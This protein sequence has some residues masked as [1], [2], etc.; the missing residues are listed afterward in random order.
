MNQTMKKIFTAALVALVCMQA[1]AQKKQPPIKGTW[2]TNVASDIL[3]SKQ[4][5]IDGVALCKKNGL[6]N[7]YV[8]VWNGGITMYPSKVLE[9][10][11]GK[12]Q[13]KIYGAR[14]PLKEIIDEGHKAGIKVHAWFEFGF[15]YNYGDSNCLWQQKYPGW[16]G[17]DVRGN[18]L[19]KNKFFW[20][21]ALNPRYS[22]L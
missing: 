2:V 9:A 4:N 14:D 11:I 20:W 5:I 15:A 16:A 6:N 7:I 21:N 18:Y 13:S 17:R 19:Q 1:A 3:K 8:V 22:N 12:K 10:Y